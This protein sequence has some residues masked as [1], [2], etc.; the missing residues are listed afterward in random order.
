[1]S[2]AMTRRER[3][4]AAVRREAVDR[5]PCVVSF[6]PLYPPQRTCWNFPWSQSATIEE[7]AA[8]QV[9]VLGLD[10]V[11]M[12][13]TECCR[14]AEGVTSRTWIEDGLLH[15]AYETPAGVLH[16]SVRHNELWAHGEDIPLMSDFNVGHFDEP[17]IRTEQDL[18]CLRYVVQWDPTGESQRTARSLYERLRRLADRY[19]LAVEAKAGEGM[20]GA[21][22][23]MGAEPLCTMVV[24]NP[25][26]VD[27]YLEFEHEINLKTIE[28]LGEWGVDI[29]NRNG[30][31][32]TADFYG[33]A[34]LERFIGPRLRRE[35]DAVRA[36]GMLS[37]YTIH[38]G[39]MPIL[40]YLAGLTMDVL[41][42]IDIAF[43]G[44][45]LERVRDRLGGGK[46]F[47]IGP[48]S[49]Y[50]L[51]SG[52]EATRDAVRRVFEVF[53]DRP[54]FILSPGVSAHSI[55]PWEST[56]ALIDEWKRLAGVR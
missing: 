47:L 7:R 43:H 55:M 37:S 39:I 36:A 31:Y 21:M 24:E 51:W 56:L 6:N 5:V 34:M 45:D 19:G 27:A 53:G 26:L 52:P 25:G 42:G 54:G 2:E 16:A 41:F 28:L 20:T 18:E 40:D 3:V 22:K 13:G 49:T 14:P 10:Q 11:L 33:P 23:M 15:K 8:Y 38:T 46:S 9:E 44:V 17:W 32:E 35:A 4:L 50:H 29:V 30:F 48:S 1:M 12:M